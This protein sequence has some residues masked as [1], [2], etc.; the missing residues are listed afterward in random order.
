MGVVRGGGGGAMGKRLAG[1]WVPFLCCHTLASEM[2]G[3]DQLVLRGEF[4]NY[5]LARTVIE[6]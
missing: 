5:N 1:C 4:L 2:L 6:S 3:P